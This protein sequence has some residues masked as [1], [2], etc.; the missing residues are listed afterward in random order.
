MNK[1]RHSRIGV[2]ALLVGIL[3]LG[4]KVLAD[5][6]DDARVTGERLAPCTSSGTMFAR[7][8]PENL[9]KDQADY[10]H[11]RRC[12]ELE[13]EQPQEGTPEY[14]E[15]Q[16]CIRDKKMPAMT[17][18][19]AAALYH[20]AVSAVVSAHMN[21]HTQ[22]TDSCKETAPF[23]PATPALSGLA[24][25]LPPWQSEERLGT[26]TEQQMTGVLLEYLRVYKCSL[27]EYDQNR[28]AS[29]EIWWYAQKNM[30]DD[31]NEYL[32]DSNPYQDTAPVEIDLL[33]NRE[34]WLA[35]EAMQ[36][37]VA[38]L[39]GVDRLHAGD[40]DF[41]CVRRASLDLR[42]VLGLLSEALSCAGR[43]LD[44]KS[45]LRDPPPIP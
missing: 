35:S 38:F 11:I 26:L 2:I 33:V 16:Q 20:A 14:D 29:D 23:K 32:P 17:V 39:G 6:T 30:V 37:T 18:N 27:F 19:D 3:L 12:G 9:P 43:A 22:K 21:L 40:V 24:G 36:R 4:G 42:N 15:L 41:E 28:F 45:S 25:Q 8:I 44:A 1:K 13:Q 31:A 10:D 7:L 34:S 5:F